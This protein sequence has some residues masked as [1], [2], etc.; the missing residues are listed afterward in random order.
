MAI[1]GNKKKKGTPEV[2]TASLPDIIFTLLFFFMVAAK[3]KDT[4][5][6]VQHNMPKALDAKKLTSDDK[7]ATIHVGKPTLQYQGIYGA[8]PQIQLQ[9]KL[10]ANPEDIKEWVIRRYQE[11]P[12]S[13]RPNFLVNLK[14]D[15]KVPYSLIDEIKL[16]LRKADALNLNYDSKSLSYE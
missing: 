7:V 2:S 6:K 3:V 5:L 8:D 9:N 16:E 10:T 4:S 14:A 11:I 12:Y 1:I 15:G 13:A